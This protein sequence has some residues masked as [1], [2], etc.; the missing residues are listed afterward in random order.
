MTWGLRTSQVREQGSQSLRAGPAQRACPGPAASEEA[1]SSWPGSWVFLGTDPA[2]APL[3]RSPIQTLQ[4]G[5]GWG[6]ASLL[7]MQGWVGVPGPVSA[8]LPACR[9]GPEASFFFRPERPP[10]S[11]VEAMCSVLR[12]EPHFSGEKM[13]TEVPDFE[14]CQAVWLTPRWQFAQSGLTLLTESPRPLI[15][16][17]SRPSL[18]LRVRS[19]A[20]WKGKWF[21]PHSEASFILHLLLASGCHYRHT[22]SPAS[23][24][25]HSSS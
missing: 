14:E 12:S 20:G 4:A 15:L 17:P 7:V 18:S 11:L 9:Q 6:S 21:S 23:P 22:P 19:R 16:L 8:V 25:S 5:W 24:A 13:E 10:P 1:L 2:P 3:E